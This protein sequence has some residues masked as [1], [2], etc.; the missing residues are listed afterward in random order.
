[1]PQGYRL[2]HQSHFVQQQQAT[3][4]NPMQHVDWTGQA[5]PS[6]TGYAGSIHFSRIFRESA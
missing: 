4:F 3:I 5:T 2:V 6:N 1:V